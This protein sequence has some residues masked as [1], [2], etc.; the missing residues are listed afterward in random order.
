MRDRV[1]AVATA[2][3]RPPYAAYAAIASTF[4]GTLAGAST[5]SS[6]LGRSREQRSAIDLVVLA[7]A[8]FKVA[9]TVSQDRVLSFVRE[10]FVAGDAR[11]GAATPVPTGDLRQALGEL[12]TCSRCV[13]TWAAA[14]LETTQLVAPRFGRLLAW[15]L[16]AAALND[17]LQ[18]GFETLR[19][20]ANTLAEQTG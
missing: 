12:V 16:A 6:R 17:W 20:R 3:A 8:S 7:A 9:R 13:G 4:A 19:Q 2:P 18:A 5:L 14:G 1:T 10:P 11:R 15:T